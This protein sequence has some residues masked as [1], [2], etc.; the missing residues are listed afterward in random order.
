MS[1]EMM[2]AAR[3]RA[4]EFAKAN[5]SVCAGEILAQ[6]ESGILKADGKV[7]ELAKLC[8][9]F[10]GGHN[11]LGVA[12]SI[13]KNLALASLAQHHQPDFEALWRAHGT[14]D[15]AYT[16]AR[17]WFDLGRSAAVTAEPGTQELLSLDMPGI[18]IHYIAGSPQGV[19][20]L[21]SGTTLPVLDKDVMWTDFNRYAL[22]ASVLALHLQPDHPV[23]HLDEIIAAVS[24]LSKL[25]G[26]IAN[27]DTGSHRVAANWL[28]DYLGALGAADY[29]RFRVL[30]QSLV[31]KLAAARQAA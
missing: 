12:E 27:V 2:I 8:A 24:D 23:F 21:L 16:V 22:V 3:E 20:V 29:Q 26:L 1:P 4:T 5:L 10:T 25:K 15:D 13:V 31:S 6:N 18:S 11:P 19:H 28:G 7:R 30:T 14:D 9:E 17:T